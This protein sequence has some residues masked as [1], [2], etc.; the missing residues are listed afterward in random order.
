MGCLFAKEKAQETKRVYYGVAVQP[1]QILQSI[2]FYTTRSHNWYDL[3]RWVVDALY[4]VDVTSVVHVDRMSTTGERNYVQ[5]LVQ[6]QEKID[7]QSENKVKDDHYY[8]FVTSSRYREWA[9]NNFMCDPTRWPL[10]PAPTF[11]PAGMYHKGK[12]VL[13]PPIVLPEP[14]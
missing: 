9:K 3:F 1:Q 13:N 2:A 8:V 7:L 6:E 12:Y 14:P 4:C 10:V 11:R 5:M